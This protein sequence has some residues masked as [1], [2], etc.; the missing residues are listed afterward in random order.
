MNTIWRDSFRSS[1]QQTSGEESR[2]TEEQKL[3]CIAASGEVGEES[4]DA[5]AVQR[6]LDGNFTVTEPY[7]S[8]AEKPLRLGRVA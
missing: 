7:T 3:Q 8:K 5:A 1:Y 4:T 6:Y 2:A